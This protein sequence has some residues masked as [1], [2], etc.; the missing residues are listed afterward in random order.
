MSL[1]I[2]G[3]SGGTNIGVSLF[4]S[5]QAIG[6]T[7]KLYHSDLAYS[8]NILVKKFNWHLRGKFPS[9]LDTFSDTILDYCR[10]YMP[11]WIVTTGIAPVHWSSLQTLGKI[12]IH[13]INFLTDDPWNAQ[14][15]AAW[16][17]KSLPHYDVVFSPRRANINDLNQAGCNRAEYLPFGYDHELFFPEI[18]STSQE[19]VPDILFAGGADADR[20]PYVHALIQGGFNLQLYG[21]YWEKYPETRSHT[22]GQANVVTLRKAITRAKI[23]LCLVRRANRDGN[24]MRTFEVPAVGAC[25]LTEDTPEHREIFGPEGEAVIY[26]QSV[27]EMLQKAQWLLEH[28]QERQRLAQNAHDLITQGKLLSI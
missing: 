9:R 10:I 4:R 2:V 7:P 26:F 12:G 24:C 17:I 19:P 11:K 20:V 16:F 23:S 25:M 1:V 8:D 6:L 5:A 14:H 28:E 15:Y 22:L 18:L 3:G 21:S 27:P 13:R